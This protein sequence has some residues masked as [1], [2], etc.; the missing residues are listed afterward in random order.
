MVLTFVL[1][2]LYKFKHSSD[3]LSSQIFVLQGC[4]YNVF[5]AGYTSVSSSSSS[6]VTQQDG[7]FLIH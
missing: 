2:C 6:V 3:S 7:P 1:Q 5:I 4:F